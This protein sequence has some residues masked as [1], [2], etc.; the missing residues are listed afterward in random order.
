VTRPLALAEHTTLGVGG[1]ADRW[2]VGES[3][4]EI[5]SAVLECDR[6]GMPVLILGGGSNMLVGDDGFRGTVIEV[7]NRGVR[8]DLDA[9]GPL[10]TVAAGENWDDLVAHAVGQGW[11]GIEALSGIPGRVG[12]TPVQNVGAY[13]QEVGQVI[14]SVRALDRSSGD[15]VT[16]TRA[17][18]GFGYRS[19]ELK[20]R[21]DRWVVLEVSFRLRGDGR[22]PVRYAELARFLDVAIDDE[23]DAALT[24]A[25]VLD[26]RR[27]KGMVLDPADPDTRSAGS[28]FMNPVVSGAEAASVPESCPRYPADEGVKLSAAWLIEQ[29]G[30]ER[31]FRARSDARAHISSKH[32]LAIVSEPGASSDDVLELARLVR[33]RVH[34]RFGITLR[35]EARLVGCAL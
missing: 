5:S 25:A 18:C 29:S 7:A 4:D 1:A 31:G 17:D 14:E 35:P 2:V 32:T 15:L 33:D 34:E 16:L 10:L 20:R 11:A 12:A 6:D 3:A 13:G 21:P 24:R 30:V 26:L 9:S 22:S 23:V 28:F 8:A 19:S 27:A